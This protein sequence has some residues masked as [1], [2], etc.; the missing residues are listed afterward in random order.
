MNYTFI[1]SM[2]KQGRVKE[3]LFA[4]LIDGEMASKAEDLKGIDVKLTISF[5][6]KGIKRVK[7]SDGAYSTEYQWIEI[8]KASGKKG[9]LFYGAEFLAF[10]TDKSFLVVERE[11][12]ADYLGRKLKGAKYSDDPAPYS[13]YKRA[14]MKSGFDVLTLIPVKDLRSIAVTE[15]VKE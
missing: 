6:V 7:R 11:R 13:L 12:L 1:N 8:K 3:E 14:G 5:N 10:E 9:W 4:K 2:L 15:I